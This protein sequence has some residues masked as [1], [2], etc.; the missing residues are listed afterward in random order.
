MKYYLSYIKDIVGNNYLGIKI[1]K[2]IVE[3]FLNEL[4]EIL[5]SEYETYINLQQQ[6]DHGSYHITVINVMDYNR[7][8]KEMGPDK[9][10]TSLENILKTPIED[11]QMWGVGMAQKN[12]N[13]TFFVVCKSQT[14]TDIRKSYKLSEFDFHTTLGFKW[15]DV[16]GVRKDQVLKKNSKFIQLLGQEYLKKENFDFIK[17]IENWED[18]PDI[19]IIPISLS[20]N[21]LKIKVGDY[22]MD[23]GLTDDFKLRI[24]TRYKNEEDIPRMSTTE[25]LSIIT[26]KDY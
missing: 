18:N 5:G 11:L 19:E 3:P 14:L 22:I 8:S 24:F 15:K 1:E 26:K 9:F 2:G 10:L 21:Y 17:K 23:I 16:F 6:R 7:L 12:D 25:L 20:E 4:K 13:R